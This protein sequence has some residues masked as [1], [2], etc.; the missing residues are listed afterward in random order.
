MKYEGLEL[1]DDVSINETFNG[2]VINR[3]SNK[4]KYNPLFVKI[5]LDIMSE[6]H[7]LNVLAHKLGVARKTISEWQ[8]KYPEFNEAIELGKESSEAFW[9]NYAY[10]NK[11]QKDIQ[12]LLLMNKCSFSEKSEHT[13]QSDHLKYLLAT[14]NHINSFEKEIKEKFKDE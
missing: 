9:E 3:Y 4:N 7:S 12:K 1:L 11:D 13:I 6:G 14:K 8:A 2:K 5:A 10:R